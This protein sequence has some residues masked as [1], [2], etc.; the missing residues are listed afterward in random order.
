MGLGTPCGLTRPAS[1]LPVQILTEDWTLRGAGSWGGAM[2]PS[3]GRALRRPPGQGVSGIRNC[4]NGLLVGKWHHL[5]D[6]NVL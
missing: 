6:R 5:E 4:V 2:V 1:P 3:R